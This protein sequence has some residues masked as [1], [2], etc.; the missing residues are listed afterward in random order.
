MIIL[1][2]ADIHGDL[3]QLARLSKEIAAA[4]L[5]LLSGDIT[6]FGHEDDAKRILTQIRQHAKCVFAVA[7]NCDYPEV[8]CYL[9]QEDV[10]L[11]R[12]GVVVDGVGLLGVGGS[13]PCPGT[14]PNEITEE[15]FTHDLAEAYAQLPPGIPTL[16]LVH[17]PPAAT[18]NDL[19]GNG[20]HV[21]SQAV[22]QFI[23][24]YQPLLC[25]TGHIHEGAGIDQIGV[26]RIVN[27]APFRQGHYVYAEV[28]QGRI[29]VEI[30]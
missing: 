30:R 23:E 15:D 17:Q 24:Q 1:C 7:G 14:T 27:P 22:R 12:R 21:G 26:T 19:A 6:H 29:T 18:R 10:S 5:V 4:D 11:H 16:L 8:E 13:L 3:S 20:Q 28:N 9:Q 25:C 2:L